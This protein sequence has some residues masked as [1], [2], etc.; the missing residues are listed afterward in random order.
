MESVSRVRLVAAAVSEIGVTFPQLLD[1]DG[2]FNERL[3]TTAVPVTVILDPRGQIA[4]M[5]TGPMDAAELR[6]AIAAAQ[7]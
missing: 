1:E 4:L 2:T 6:Q 5:H 7:S 3:G